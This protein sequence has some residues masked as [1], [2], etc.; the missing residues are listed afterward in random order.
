[1]YA[2]ILLTVV[3]GKDDDIYDSL[4]DCD[5]IKEVHIVF[6]EW[7]MIAKIEMENS[8][9][10]ATFIL[11]KVRSLKGVQLTSTIIVAK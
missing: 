11:E 2:Y 5:E 9:A 1:M 6:G 7:D 3:E 8:D 10:L 4:S